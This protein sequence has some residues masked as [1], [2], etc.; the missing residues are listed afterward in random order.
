MGKVPPLP[1]RPPGLQ[2]RTLSFNMRD[3]NNPDLRR[4][5]LYGSISPG[6]LVGM[7]AEQLASDARRMEDEQIREHQKREAV[8][9]GTQAASTDMFQVRRG[10]IGYR[11][12]PSSSRHSATAR[13]GSSA[14]LL[15]A[16]GGA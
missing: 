5:V 11:A 4:R 14:C 8:R 6:A 2:A 10:R 13:A 1:R 16:T 7:S 9:G 12:A 15:L 3:G